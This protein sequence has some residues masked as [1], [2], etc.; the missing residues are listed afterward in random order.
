M[1]TR[2]TSLASGR[3]GPGPDYDW[4]VTTADYFLGLRAWG[5]ILYGA[6]PANLSLLGVL[7]VKLA[8]VADLVLLLPL[9]VVPLLLVFL[10]IRSRQR[11]WYLSTDFLNFRSAL[12]AL[13][14]LLLATLIFGLSGLVLKGYK[15]APQALAACDC[16]RLAACWPLKGIV[17]SFLFAVGSLVLS[18]TLFMTIMTKGGDLPGL[19]TGEFTKQLG[20]IREKLRRVQSAPVWNVEG[21]DCLK[22]VADEAKKLLGDLRA[23]SGNDLAKRSLRRVEA[24]LGHFIKAADYI[25]GPAERRN[26]SEVR[27]QNWAL[28]FA[29]PESLSR[30]QSDDRDAKRDAYA[31]VRRLKGLKLGG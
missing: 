16:S 1:S 3:A 24:D 14:I 28:Y 20:A 19:P 15:F 22:S 11:D 31:A 25:D 27:A 21:G 26:Q 29:P 17:E 6:L 12:H 13:L 2:S 23:V 18:S 30:R 9:S 5:L 4:R 10:L 7:D 8:K